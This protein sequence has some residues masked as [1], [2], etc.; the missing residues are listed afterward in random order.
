MT[1][2]SLSRLPGERVRAVAPDGQ[3]DLTLSELSAY[4]R[5]RERES[6][7]WV[8]DDTARW[9]P[10]LLAAGV[11]VGRCHDLR[12]AHHLLRR[13]PAVDGR[14]LEG[15]ESQHWDGLGPS[16]PSHP[17]LFSVDDTAEHLRAD[18][19]D[20]RQRAAVEA[21][22][23]SVRL[24]LLLAAESSGALA[25]AEMTYAGVP[26]RTD[27]HERLLTDLLGP[28]PPRGAR[29]LLLEALA[30]E[31]RAAFDAPG[32]NPDSRPELLAA[33][34]RAGL[35][36]DDTR[37]SSLRALE[38]PGVAPLLRYK[39]LAHL[40]STNGWSWIDQWVREGRFRPSYQPAG[41]ATGRWSSNGGGALSIPL[42]VRPAAIADDGWV[43]VVADVA[44]LEPRVLAGMSG[45]RALAR[46]A[47]GA[48]LYQGMVDDGAVATRQHA[49][50]GL[51]G[52]MYGATS[53]ES[54]RMV[55]GLT[56][57][58][59]EAFGLV[60][61]AAR[62]G[63]RGQVVRT[64]LGR[65]SPGLGDAWERDPEGPP[66]DP[67]SQARRRRAF[68]RFTRNFV[69]QGTGAEW[70]LC[71]VADLRNRLWRLGGTGEL[72][73]RP[74]LVFFLHDE[75]VVHTP[76]ALADVVAAEAAEAAS[77]ASSLLF[78]DLAI[79]FPLN[80]SVVRSYA[81]AGKP[82]AVVPA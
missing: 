35:E 40:F 26:W 64:L 63:E 23:E 14:L 46:S 38:H 68:G 65:G 75:I 10:P 11:R 58:Y 70:A 72:T 1:R 51:L 53:G 16:A 15:E 44:Q 13:A 60:E 74:H 45:D 41:S 22:A 27:V 5:E 24:G 82:G 78:R 71:W 21:S 49:K 34:R 12:L 47:R 17:A 42:Q 19:E 37:A 39:Q 55:A 59:P 69:V 7:R 4:V 30:G 6:P 81:D 48:D 9:Y 52:A 66:A 43:L 79:D 80:V 28:R 57:R 54:G 32:L 36:T 50:L 20:A 18:L 73:S 29:P 31:V 56:R 77:T 62:A 61:E 3:V 67:E 25:A 8:W 76:R 2:V 33:L